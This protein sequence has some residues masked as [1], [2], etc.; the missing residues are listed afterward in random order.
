MTVLLLVL[1][2]FAGVDIEQSV[3]N[4]SSPDAKVREEAQ[5]RLEAVGEGAEEALIRAIPDLAGDGRIAVID[6]LSAIGSE[7][8]LET[9]VV[10]ALEESDKEVRAAARGALRSNR[11]GVVDILLDE[12]HGLRDDGV[13][14][15]IIGLLGMLRSGEA[16]G[17][18]AGA[19]LSKND[20]LR[21]AATESLIL[22][23]MSRRSEVERALAGLSHIPPDAEEEI[24]SAFLDETVQSHLDGLITEEGSTGY[25]RGQFDEVKALGNPAARVLWEIATRPQFRFKIPPR[26]GEAHYRIVRNLAIRAL[27]E[28]GDAA[29]KEKLLTIPRLPV[30][31]TYSPEDFASLAHALYLRGE[32][33][34]Y[35]EMLKGLSRALA[36]AKEQGR[37]DDHIQIAGTLSHLYSRVEDYRSTVKV[38]EELA[39][40][41]ES[42]GDLEG[43]PVLRTTYYN[44]ACALAMMDR[45][46]DALKSLRKALQAGYRDIEW[47]RMDKDLDGL[48]GHDGFERLL[49]EYFKGGGE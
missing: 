22:I 21:E 15:E 11:S 42:N 12:L 47:I 20:L 27:G 46:E 35:E 9:I 32:R 19:L 7:D 37:V 8:A 13:E 30:F 43:D 17:Y 10:L 40:S 24:R 33:K 38:L 23:G 6:L 41:V 31:R 28:V 18:L 29:W 3:R 2:G 34:Y 48:R 16:V 39:A 14:I 5:E 4:L 26:T 25:F 45:S 36:T 49:K 44:I 1:A